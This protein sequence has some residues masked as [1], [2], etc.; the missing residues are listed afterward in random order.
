VSD[1]QP[2][3]VAAPSMNWRESHDAS[4][5]HY[6]Y[7]QTG[8]MYNEPLIIYNYYTNRGDIGIRVVATTNMKGR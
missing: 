6:R 2:R 4:Q 8:V 5:F 3:V 1:I 7:N